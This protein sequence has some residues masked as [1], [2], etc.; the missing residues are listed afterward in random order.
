MHLLLGS[1]LKERGEAIWS[2]ASQLFPRPPLCIGFYNP[3][4]NIV[5]DTLRAFMRY[6][7]KNDGYVQRVAIFFETLLGLCTAVNPQLRW[8]HISH[9][10][11]GAIAH[12]AL[13]MVH[14]RQQRLRIT[15]HDIREHLISTAY[16]P[17]LPIPKGFALH[18]FN[19]YSEKDHTTWRFGKRY[20]GHPNYNIDLLDSDYQSKTFLP[21]GDH[22]FLGDTYQLALEN[23]LKNI[24]RRLIRGEL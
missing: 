4:Q 3:T 8:I 14:I 5:M 6:A 15:R 21:P 1:H 23:N 10:E 18:T 17:V 16:G 13:R 20:Y 9:S 24:L 2:Q 7:H 11:G 22:D 12:L 19:S